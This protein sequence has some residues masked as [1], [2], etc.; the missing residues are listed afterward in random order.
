MQSG[1]IIRKKNMA[2]E[3][4]RSEDFIEYFI[5]PV[6]SETSEGENVREFDE[7]Y[8]KINEIAKSYCSNYIWHKDPFNIKTK[9]FSTILNNLERDSGK[10][11]N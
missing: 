8:Q 2:L 7:L 6:I 11:M 10:L 9:Q 1:K 5:F 4:V 3:I